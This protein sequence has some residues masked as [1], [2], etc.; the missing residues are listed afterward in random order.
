MSDDIRFPLATSSWD[1]REYAAIERVVKSGMFSMGPE[2]V[3]D[4]MD[5]TH[6]AARLRG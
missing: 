2:V 1:E 4:A 5:S 6:A 3:A